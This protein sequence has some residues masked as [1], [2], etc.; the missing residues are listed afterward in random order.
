MKNKTWRQSLKNAASGVRRA[1]GTERNFKVHFAAAYFALCAALYLKADGTELL[2]I[3][4]AIA[5]VF[6]AEMLNTAVENAVNH[7]AGDEYAP[8]AKA[9][10]DAAAGAV[11]ITAAFSVVVGL[12]VFAP[13]L[14][15]ADAWIKDAGRALLAAAA[16]GLAAFAAKKVCDFRA[17]VVYGVSTAL[18]FLTGSVADAVS[19]YALAFLFAAGLAAEMPGRAVNVVLGGLCG[20]L[21]A[22][23]VFGV[24][25]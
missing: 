24:W 20:I 4:F 16:S 15:H 2:F 19:G 8:W 3:I 18:M 5:L 9:A 21:I 22:A 6:T 1:V 14:A 12:I 17:A 13:K 10:K 7:S 11:L 25:K 23:A